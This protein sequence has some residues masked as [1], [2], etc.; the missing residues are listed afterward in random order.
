MHKRFSAEVEAQ[1]RLALA[2]AWSHT[3]TIGY[4]KMTLFAVGDFHVCQEQ[5]GNGTTTSLLP[6][7]RKW[8]HCE[9]Q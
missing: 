3:L 5:P 7:V 8:R 6:I 1:T 4:S 9:G 2:G